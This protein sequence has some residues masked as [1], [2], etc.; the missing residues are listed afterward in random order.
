MALS[1]CGRGST[2][3][4]LEDNVYVGWEQEDEVTLNWKKEITR[5]TYSRVAV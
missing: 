4:A 5:T 1:N 2:S 3:G